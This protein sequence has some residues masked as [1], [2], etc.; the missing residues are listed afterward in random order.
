MTE[1]GLVRRDDA[2]RSHVF[3]ARMT[4][5]QTQRQL[6]GDL[7]DRAFGGSASRLVMQAL[8]ARPATVEEL[9]R[10]RRLIDEIEG[11]KE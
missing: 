2:D 11:E 4:E 10:I 7:L 6:V 3:E 9:D 5:A 8:S 1:K